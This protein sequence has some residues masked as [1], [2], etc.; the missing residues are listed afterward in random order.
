MEVDQ[1]SSLQSQH[2]EADTLIAFHA[3]KISDG[4]ILVRSSDTD[5]FI[6]LL[7]LCGRSTGMNII[8]DYGSDNTLM[9]QM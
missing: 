3:R 1:P 2:E 6:I 5:V 9:S 4:N 8:M 7:G